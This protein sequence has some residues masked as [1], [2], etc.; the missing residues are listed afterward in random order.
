MSWKD[1]GSGV[2]GFGGNFIVVGYMSRKTHWDYPC[3]CASESKGDHQGETMKEGV[4][5]LHG[6]YSV[7]SIHRSMKVFAA[8][9]IK[10]LR[11]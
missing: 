1:H 9:R 3:C 5:C 6:S 10:E 7:H 4:L 11:N 8:M 2:L